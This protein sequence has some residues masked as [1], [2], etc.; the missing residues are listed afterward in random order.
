MLEY[1]RITESEKYLVTE[2][3]YDGDYAIYNNES[4]D[5][6]KETGFGFANSKNNFFAF[7]DDDILVGY[8]NLY[9]ESTEVFFG[10][11]INPLCCEKGYGQQITIKTIEL[12]HKLFPNK[13]FIWK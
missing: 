5:R 11:G 8:T 12:S 10:I 4:Y 13:L 2:W 1:H 6:Q 9:E 7:Y 3:K